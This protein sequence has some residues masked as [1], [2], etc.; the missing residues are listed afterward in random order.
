MTDL[1]LLSIVIGLLLILGCLAGAFAVLRKKRTINDLPTSK[2]QGVFIGLTELKGTAES[3]QPFTAWLSGIKCV[4][5]HWQVEEEWRRTVTESY[6]D[7]KGRMQT[8]TKVE[9]G[10]KQVAAGG[11]KAPF[12]LK[13]DSGVIR[14]I[15]DGAKIRDN[16]T[17]NQKVN[18]SNPLYYSHGPSTAIANST[19]QRRFIER[20]LPLHITLYVLG[21]ARQRQDIV[22]AEIAQNKQSS[23][24]II[25]TATEK[26]ISRGYAGWFWMWM[27]FG[28]L[29]A[30]GSAFG[31][32]MQAGAGSGLIWQPWVVM[33]LIY[34]LIS[35]LV[36]LWTTYNN[37]INLKHRVQQAWSQV[38]VQIKRRFDLIP[39]L[40]KALEAYQ[41]HE[42]DTQTVLV[43][44]RS[45][46]AATPA[47]ESGPEYQS[48]TLTLRV[49]VEKYPELKAV[50]GYLKLHSA[51][52][53]SEQRIALA[54]DYFNQV[55]TFYNTRLDIIPERYVAALAG[56]KHRRLMSAGDFERAPVEV[57]LQI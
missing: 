20:A 2:T 19:H 35:L 22:A 55:T 44:L 33:V 48:L 9:S 27:G 29:A 12:Y 38:D 46:M 11:E 39:N 8:R 26:Q 18:R 17:F 13:D 56:L 34:G 45:Q 41:Q 30:L 25:S 57:H 47:G 14:V 24:F 7:S 3:E 49:L 51:L 53:D 54:R 1:P 37:L 42:N 4:C 36:Y 43:A 6:R 31:W 28:L 23:L 16:S 40:V 32:Q 10:W 21:Q 50:E 5:Y 52:V 15:P